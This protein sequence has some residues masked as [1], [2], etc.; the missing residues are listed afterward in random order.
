MKTKVHKE[1][2]MF[3]CLTKYV[4]GLIQTVC[5]S[6]ICFIMPRVS[7]T[8]VWGILNRKD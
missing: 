2:Y 7:V 8:D 5:S 3:C 4:V 6:I 1:A